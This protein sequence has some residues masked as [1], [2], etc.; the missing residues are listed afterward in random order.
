VF[1]EAFVAQAAV[2]G[3]DEAILHRFA[4]RNVVPLDTT[5][6]LPGRMAFEVSSVP[7][8]LTIM[9]G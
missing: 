7:L 9:Q 1:V 2:E 6:L 8:S 4:G 3:L 5:F